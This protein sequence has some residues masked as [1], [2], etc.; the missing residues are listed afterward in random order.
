MKDINDPPLP[1]F[2]KIDIIRMI[3]DHVLMSKP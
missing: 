3:V 1:Y 2:K